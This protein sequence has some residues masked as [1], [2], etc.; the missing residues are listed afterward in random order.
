MEEVKTSIALL[1]AVLLQWSLTIVAPQFA[2]VDF[3]LLI[4]VYVALQRESLKAMLYATVAGLAVDALGNGLLGA[5]G[6]SKTVTA[7][8]VAEIARRVLLLDNPLLRIPVIAGA[9]ALTNLIYFSMHR[10]LGQ[11]TSAPFPETIGYAALGTTVAGTIVMLLIEW[12]FSDRARM[13][14]RANTNNYSARRSS[15][16]GR[17]NT[18]RLGKRI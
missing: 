4:I 9:S 7:F 10:L 3:P 13:Q 15:N 12:F 16:T 6:F 5:G 11:T 2:Y 17:R 1:I 8:V 14:R 18:I